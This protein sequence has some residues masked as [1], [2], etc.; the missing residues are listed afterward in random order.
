[1]ADATDDRNEAEPSDILSALDIDNLTSNFD[2]RATQ[3]NGTNSIIASN[4]STTNRVA[5]TDR[6]LHLGAMCRRRRF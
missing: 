2:A 1:M 4:I 5:P 3:L 6:Q